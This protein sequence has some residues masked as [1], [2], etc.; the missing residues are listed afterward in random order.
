[1]KARANLWLN[2]KDD[3]KEGPAFS[4]AFDSDR[5]DLVNIYGYE[6]KKYVFIRADVSLT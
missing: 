3:L 5:D 6:D 1:M 4:V 2:L